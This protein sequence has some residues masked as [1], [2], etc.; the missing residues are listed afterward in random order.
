MAP[1]A[2]TSGSAGNARFLR[3]V[4]DAMTELEPFFSDPTWREDSSFPQRVPALAQDERPQALGVLEVA[5]AFT[6][7]VCSC[8]AKKIFDEIYDRLLKRPL[9]PFLDRLF[10][11]DSAASGKSV[12]VRDVIYLE[13]IDTTVVV[14]AILSAKDANEANTLLL[15]GHRVAY[16]YIAAH[17]RKA[18]VHCHTV[19]DGRINLE[20]EL[21]LSLNHEQRQGL[22]GGSDRPE[23]GPTTERTPLK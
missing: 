23:A 3:T 17:G 15:H 20:P 18:P 13:D 2:Y 22:L 14:R 12:E 19:Q 8:F 1:V 4:A 10:A 5:G 9:A 7:F 6:I 16:L 11:P 21:Y